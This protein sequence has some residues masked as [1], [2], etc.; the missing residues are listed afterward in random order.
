MNGTVFS[1]IAEPA[2]MAENE[3]TPI[4]R[5]MATKNKNTF[6][7]GPGRALLWTIARLP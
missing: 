3:L 6:E 1:S 2:Q 7:A 4:F 5:Q